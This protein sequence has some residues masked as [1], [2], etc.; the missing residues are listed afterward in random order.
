MAIA[1]YIHGIH[2]RT[3]ITTA[4]GI[5]D[6]CSKSRTQLVFGVWRSPKCRLLPG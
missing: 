6:Y 5:E 3:D 4:N 1:R 2:L